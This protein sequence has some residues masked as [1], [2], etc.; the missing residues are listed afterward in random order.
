M[1]SNSISSTDVAR[2]ALLKIDDA[3]VLA[4][5]DSLDLRASAKISAVVGFPLRTLQ[6]RRDV[7]SFAATAPMPAVVGILELL[8]IAPQERIISLLGDHADSPSFE[9][10]STAVDQLAID[11]ATTDELVAL[12][13][14]AVSE[15]FPA[16]GHCQR[17]LE[18]RPQFELPPLPEVESTPTLL[19]P[20]E[21]D[22]EVR[23]QRRARRELERQRK[24][25]PTS[26]RPVRAPKSKA[27]G[28]TPPAPSAPAVVGDVD[29]PLERRR[30][31][32]TP[33]ESERFDA[34]HPLV[35]T[36]VLVDVPFDAVDPAAP[37]VTSKNRPALVV[38]AN[39]ESVLIRPIYSNASSTR[40]LFQPW[41][42]L[43]LDHVSYIDDARL[44]VAMASDGPL[45]RKGQLT[46]LEW[47]ALL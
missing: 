21:T 14:F 38:A 11:G 39:D 29:A 46:D 12:L 33:L 3:V 45:V 37:E 18:E 17:L 6:Q 26:T 22:P 30:Y 2:R 10:L 20:R 47:N 35:G 8:A 19:S 16:A 36:V 42:R 9:Q 43:G 5:V 13:A 34:E 44:S 27:L 40:S 15:K 24:K 4:A 31:L 7:T 1:T 41:R 25:G 28:S 23:E 32:F